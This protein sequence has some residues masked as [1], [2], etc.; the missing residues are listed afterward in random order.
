L[1]RRHFGAVG[2]C[3]SRPPGHAQ[4]D[5]GEAI[6]IIGGC[7]VKLHLFCMHLPHSDACFVKAY[8]AETTEALLDGIAS[9]FGFFG[10]VPR[11]VLLDNM[12]LAVVRILPDGRRERT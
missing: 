9:G 12:K 7:R 3:K 11:S 1:E 6:G 2:R 5:F 4:I 10:G 8:P